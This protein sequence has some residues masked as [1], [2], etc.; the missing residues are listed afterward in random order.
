[1]HV[2]T[3][4]GGLGAG[5]RVVGPGVGGW[6][7]CGRR[8]AP[9]AA[10]PGAAAVRAITA[11]RAA[12]RGHRLGGPLL[13]QGAGLVALVDPDLHADT[14]EGGLGLEEAVVDVGTQRVHRHSTRVAELGAAH[15]GAAQAAGAV[16][17]D[18]RHGTG[19]QPGLHR[20]RHGTTEG[21]TVAQLLGDALG[22][23]LR[24]RF[25]VAHLEDVQ[26]HL[27][28]GELLQLTADA[29]GLRAAAA[30]H[31][32]RPGGVDVDPHPVTSALDLHL[33]DAGAL[34]AGVQQLADLDVLGHVVGIGLV[35]VPA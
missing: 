8:R 6:R 9:V 12:L 5:G 16:D 35:C 21:D 29:V 1:Q 30:D 7:R 25:G 15:V 26:L 17:L 2:S 24:I 23:E 33:G 31:D 18:A 4:R 19:P 28:A 22:D 10:A 3:L 20:L 32:A 11:S 14:A 27:L 13:G 34:H